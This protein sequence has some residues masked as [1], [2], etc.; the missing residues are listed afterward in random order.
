MAQEVLAPPAY[1]VRA[2]YGADGDGGEERASEQ[3]H[4]GG[5]HVR[6]RGP[7]VILGRNRKR[8]DGWPGRR[9]AGRA[10]GGG[11]GEQLCECWRA[12]DAGEVAGQV[13]EG[14][15]GRRAVWLLPLRRRANLDSVQPALGHL[16]ASVHLQRPKVGAQPRREGAHLGIDERLRHLFARRVNCQR[17]LAHQHGVVRLVLQQPAAETVRRL[18]D[19]G[20]FGGGGEAVEG[21]VHVH[22]QRHIGECWLAQLGCPRPKVEPVQHAEN[23]H[24]IGTRGADDGVGLAVVVEQRGAHDVLGG[25][26]DEVARL[27]EQLDAPQR[28]VLPKGRHE[29]PHH[30]QRIV[31]REEVPLRLA[32][33][34][35]VVL[36]VLAAGPAVQV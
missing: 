17:P 32:G 8:A 22:V 15:W 1:G 35:R 9:L 14:V 5:G 20:V 29:R 3:R 30:R 27:V 31:D 2:P 10:A 28:L 25:S 33:A 13:R 36:A 23:D 16:R 26:R 6:A 12:W 24:H 7:S 11:F 21:G 4:A 34:P 19:L 18:H